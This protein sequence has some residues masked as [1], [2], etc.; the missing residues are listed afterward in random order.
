MSEKK[1]SNIAFLNLLFDAC[2]ELS[3]FEINNINMHVIELYKKHFI[4]NLKLKNPSAIV[5]YIDASWRITSHKNL[6]IDLIID[7]F[8]DNGFSSILG[9]NDILINHFEIGFV[10][11]ENLSVDNLI[12]NFAG[13]KTIIKKKNFKSNLNTIYPLI[14]DFMID[15]VY[16]QYVKYGIKDK[17]K[18]LTET[19][20]S[21]IGSV[22]IGNLPLHVSIIENLLINFGMVITS[23]SCDE[24]K[25]YFCIIKFKNHFVILPKKCQKRKR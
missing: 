7:E 13:N 23:S 3:I 25:K 6:N 16:G 24:I 11:I 20:I 5:N 4:N 1:S 17:K 22:D 2:Q 15:F 9:S 18:I 21:N 8:I 10:N 14:Y 19:K 12:L